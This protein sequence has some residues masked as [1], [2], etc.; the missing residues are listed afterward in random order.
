MVTHGPLGGPLGGLPGVPGGEVFAAV[1]AARRD[2]AV[3]TG[4][5]P[6]DRLLPAGGVRRG[7]LVEWLS[8]DEASAAATFAAAVACRLA[9][10][11]PAEHGGEAAQAPTIVVVDRPGRFYPP[12]VL[13]WLDRAQV[14]GRPVPRLVVARPA[15]A[16]DE[17]WAIDQAIRCR[18]V[19]AVLAWPRG[20]HATAMRRWQLAARSS[21]AVGLFVRPRAAGREPSWAEA[22]VAVSAAPGGSLGTRRL[23]LSLVGGPWSG[24]DQVEERSVELGIDLA[25]G[26]ESRPG[27]PACEPRVS[28]RE[29]RTCRAS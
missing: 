21:L 12:A 18:G 25:R 19:A 16:A 17:A 2:K 4:F 20:I 13:G 28:E 11:W 14:P 6:L 1:S 8:G 26:C 23:R 22:R 24:A 5:G 27:W 9:G 3:P 15:N 10:A 7:S 29:R